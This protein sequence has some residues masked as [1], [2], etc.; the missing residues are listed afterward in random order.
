MLRGTG[1]RRAAE[2]LQASALQACAA[3]VPMGRVDRFDEGRR[4]W[5]SGCRG[6]REDWG[7]DRHKGE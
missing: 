3:A 7:R 2:P 1:L 5:E 4:H 6:L